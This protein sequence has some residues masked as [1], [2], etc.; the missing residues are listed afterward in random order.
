[1]QRNHMQF[2]PYDVLFLKQQGIKQ[3]EQPSLVQQFD[4]YAQVC[5]ERD[6]WR[7]MHRSTMALVDRYDKELGVAAKVASQMHRAFCFAACAAAG[8]ALLSV[9]LWLTR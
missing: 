4:S 8:F 5:N 7:T 3:T 6:H 9:I 1:M 2:S